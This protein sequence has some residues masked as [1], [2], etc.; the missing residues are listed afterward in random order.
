MPEVETV[1]RSLE[2]PLA[3][4][5]IVSVDVLRPSAVAYPTVRDFCTQ[6]TGQVFNGQS[7]RRGKY[8]CLG[9]THGGWLGVHLRMS[10]RLL[11]HQFPLPE[12][13]T[14]VR[15]TFALSNGQ[16]L[17]FQDPRAFGRL[18]YISPAESLVKVISTLQTL[19]PEPEDL[20]AA[21]LA[22]VFARRAI[23][24]KVALLD[25]TVLAGL[26][27]I[28]ADEVLFR[29]KL[30][31]MTPAQR[32]TQARLE[33][34]VTAVREILATAVAAGGTTLRDYVDGRGQQ[35]HYQLQLQVYG[36]FQKPCYICG[37][38]ILRIRLAGRSSH[39]C[40]QCQPHS[41]ESTG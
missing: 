1:R 41:D 13:N 6:L 28:Y 27:N 20:T 4:L 10:G 14:H 25:Q 21:H 9:L 11:L 30:H 18:W 3:D 7:Q 19:G 31:P 39:F 32:L 35:G 16:R 40:G 23:P 29:A 22:R 12:L 26:G 2:K 8:L 5:E 17:D 37:T 15:V 36:R 34:M 38:P 33:M 24:I